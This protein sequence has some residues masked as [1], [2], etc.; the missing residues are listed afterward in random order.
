MAVAATP[1]P[2]IDRWVSSRY[3]I[4][5]R[6]A[7]AVSAGVR[8]R[9]RAR[10]VLPDQTLDQSRQV[11]EYPVERLGVDVESRHRPV[12][13]KRR[14]DENEQELGAGTLTKIAG[15]SQDRRELVQ[16]VVIRSGQVESFVVE[17]QR[18]SSSSSCCGPY[19]D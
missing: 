10:Q 8:S 1:W 9:K 15:V 3:T 14:W 18:R 13:A 11:V 12:D 2:A 7:S 19:Q 4:F 17:D 16:G 6:R 5:P